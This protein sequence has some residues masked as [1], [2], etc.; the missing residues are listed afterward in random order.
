M[1]TWRDFWRTETILF[2]IY[3][4][5]A[6]LGLRG[7]AFFDPG[8]L[9]HIRVGELILRD[10]R[11]MQTDPF[12]F[13]FAGQ[14]WRPQQWGA[15]IVLALLHRGGGLDAILLALAVLLAAFASWLTLRFI[16][17]GFHPLAAAGVVLFGLLAA[18]FHIY[19]RPHV[20]TILLIGLVI[21][22]G[23]DFERKRFG[24]W[25]WLVLF[26]LFVVWT[27]LHGGVLGGIGTVGLA[28]AGWIVLF[29]C[30]RDSPVDS[31]RTAAI[32]AGIGVLYLLAPLVNP[33]GLDM[34]RSW[35]SIVGSKLVPMIIIEHAP[36]RVGSATG[37][38]ILMF[39]L[40]YL[41]ML[42]GTLPRLPRI[43]WLLPLAWLALSFRS[44]RHG[45]LF[46]VAGLVALAD[47]MPHTVWYRLLRKHGE[48][49]T[50]EARSTEYSGWLACVIPVVA[51]A[52]VALIPNKVKL[53]SRTAPV[54]LVEPLREYAIAMPAGTPIFNDAN[55]GG[56]VIYFEPRLKVFMDDRFELYG[57]AFTSQYV[58]MMSHHPEDIADW[59]AKYGFD[60]ALVA[61]GSPM[62]MHL[63]KSWREV[64]RGQEAVLFAR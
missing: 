53:G 23:V 47:L 24:P 36:L 40:F 21:A 1:P 5:I 50:R 60:R 34:I 2:L 46:C 37:L 28:I 42:A 63:R 11:I 52:A 33:Y 27:N 29:L 20:A 64:A 8:A 30:R 61:S 15:E 22:F 19:A 62:D 51:I 14:P 55:L 43:S 6:L 58:D 13:T 32:L 12:S 26:P 31:W 39:A 4:A 48:M 7:K 18:A 49:I 44:I 38:A 17:G 3:F 59:C 16:V 25:R 35:Y 41:L 57:E 45:P 54:E 9:W 56:F 10:G